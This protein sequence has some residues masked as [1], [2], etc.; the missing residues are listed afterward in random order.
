MNESIFDQ[1][2]L[3]I[4]FGKVLLLKDETF[5]IEKIITNPLKES[6]IVVNNTKLFQSIR[7]INDTL[8]LKYAISSVELAMPLFRIVDSISSML[9]RIQQKNSKGMR[10]IAAIFTSE[11]EY[12]INKNELN[13]LK[14]SG[15]FSSIGDKISLIIVVS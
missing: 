15:L 1:I 14:Q 2:T 3:P 7:D 8:S 11:A 5:D 13:L 6:L 9:K 12:E 4:E 10:Y